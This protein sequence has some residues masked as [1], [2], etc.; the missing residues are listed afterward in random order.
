MKRATIEMESESAITTLT[1]AERIV[2]EIRYW[3]HD[4]TEDDFMNYLYYFTD[5]VFAYSNYPSLSVH[6]TLKH[7]ST[8]V[9][10]KPDLKIS[11]DYKKDIQLDLFTV[12][13]KKSSSAYAPNKSD[14]IKI[15]L[16]MKLMLD[17]Q[18]KNNVD[19]PVVFGV[20][21]KG[22]HIYK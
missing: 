20:L 10:L 5:E 15:N 6:K 8:D 9:S 14:F 7:L 21:V 3:S 2:K 19:D 16:E 18:I 11:Y 1:T 4:G 13:L 22:I 12:E 17:M